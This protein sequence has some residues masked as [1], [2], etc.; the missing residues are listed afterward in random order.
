MSTEEARIAVLENVVEDLHD[1]LDSMKDDLKAVRESLTHVEL[2][3]SQYKGFFGGV[4]FTVGAIAGVVG[5]VVASIWH[6]LST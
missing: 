4:V 3:V 2:A 5:A 6:K 1:D